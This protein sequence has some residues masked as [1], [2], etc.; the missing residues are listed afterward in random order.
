MTLLL[1]YYIYSLLLTCYCY[2]ILYLFI[3]LLINLYIYSLLLMGFT[4][5][6]YYHIIKLIH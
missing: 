2:I 4:L 1:D 6:V 3:I 5:I